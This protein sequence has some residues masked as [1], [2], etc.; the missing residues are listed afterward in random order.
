MEYVN[1]WIGPLLA[2]V[3]AFGPAA[4]DSGG[5]GTGAASPDDDDDG[6]D[7]DTDDDVDDTGTG[8]LGVTIAS[9][10]DGSELEEGDSL[11]FEAS[12]EGGEPPFEYSWSFD[13]AAPAS[14]ALSPGAIELVEPGSYEATLT[15]TD[16]SEQTAEAQ[17]GFD[18]LSAEGD[19]QYWF[20]NLHS[21]SGYSD[22][23]G[24][25]AEVLAWARDEAGLDF[26]AMTDHSE[27]LFGSEWEE[28]G[29]QVALA[30]EA[31]E[32]VAL[33]GFEWSH[34]INGHVCIYDTDDYTAAYFAIWINFIYD[35]IDERDAF[36][37]FNHPGREIGVFNDL[38]LETYVVDNFFAIET[39]NK[40]D[41]N[42]DGEFLPYYTQALDNGWRVAPVSNQDNHSMSV[43]SHRTVYV[44][45]TLSSDGLR[46]AMG[47][48][49]LYSTDDPDIEIAFKLGDA[50]MGEVV[51]APEDSARFTVKVTDDEPIVAVELIGNGDTVIAE[52]LPGP[53]TSEL[54]WKPEVPVTS[55]DYVFVK[56]TSTDELDGDGPEQIAVTAPIWFE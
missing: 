7:A 32:F 50:W 11:V 43:N 41:G 22:G 4:C 19:M 25:P 52:Q 53:D 5:G 13:G 6:G 51:P 1:L 12:V 56:V 42:N 28:I 37:Q 23:E 17:V 48:R 14:A 30:D 27:Q 47:A 33:R 34:P 38:D 8:G 31:G 45:P 55:G 24:D 15:V 3:L 18:V 26:Y 2:A 16:S 10:T 44:G 35:W 21:H 29:V 49:R 20:G 46:A 9:P 40:G 39:G 36:A 54:L